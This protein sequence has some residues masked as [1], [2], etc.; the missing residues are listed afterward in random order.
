MLLQFSTS[1]ATS[2][3]ALLVHCLLFRTVLI[4]AHTIYKCKLSELMHTLVVH[5]HRGVAA[6]SYQTGLM[7]ACM[8]NCF[9]VS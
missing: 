2:N 9:D 3:D 1:T 4:A 6:T 8:S 7:L 5:S